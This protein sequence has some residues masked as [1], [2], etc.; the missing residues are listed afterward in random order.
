[1]GTQ[2]KNQLSND[3]KSGGARRDRTADLLHAMQALSQLSYGPTWRRGTL[4]DTHQFVK[5]MN[6]LRA[7]DRLRP[8][9]PGQRLGFA[10]NGQRGVD[11]RRYRATADGQ[12]N[13]LR[14]LA[15]RNALPRRDAA[16]NLVNGCRA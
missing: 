6:G 3:L 9:Q 4:P 16:D 12:P 7:P 1:M 11:G 13:G 8:R 10:Q 5:K 2:A 15:K 14:K